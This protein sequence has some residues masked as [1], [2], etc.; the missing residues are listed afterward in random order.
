MDRM[1]GFLIGIG[2]CLLVFSIFT[3]LNSL[4]TPV[5]AGSG[6]QIAV[7]TSTNGICN[8]TNGWL[9]TGAFGSG[10][11]CAVT[12]ATAANAA[13]NAAGATVYPLLPYIGIAGGLVLIIFGKPISGLVGQNMKF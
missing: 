3:G 2:V 5:F 13:T 8:I 4:L 10:L 11:N 6:S 9:G 7:A 12:N 1:Y